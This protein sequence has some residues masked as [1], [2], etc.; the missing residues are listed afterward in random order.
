[1]SA[2]YRITVDR[3]VLDKTK[4]A[5]D[6]RHQLRPIRVEDTRT[7]KIANHRDVSMPM[8]ARIVY[9]DPQQN[10]ARVWIE[11]HAVVGSA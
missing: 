1:M 2:R 4:P 9:G 6:P 11:A 5:D 8:G 10:G 7:G 3:D